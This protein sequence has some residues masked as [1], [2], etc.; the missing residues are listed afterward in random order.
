MRSVGSL[1]RYL[2]ERH[3]LATRAR[4]SEFFKHV[5]WHPDITEVELV[6]ELLAFLPDVRLLD[7]FS[8]TSLHDQAKTLEGGNNIADAL[9]SGWLTK[10]RERHPPGHEPVLDTDFNHFDQPLHPDIAAEIDSMQTRQ[11]STMTLLE[12]CRRVRENQSWGKREEAL[13]KSITPAV[14]EAAIVN[15][16]GDN[17]KLILLQ[18]MDF[19][20]NRDTYEIH[21]GSAIPSFL[22]ACRSVVAREPKAPIAKV[23][24]R[25]FRSAG[26]EGEL[27]PTA[28]ALSA[29]KQDDSSADLA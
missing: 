7:M 1:D 14:Y 22:E 29:T 2:S 9:I 17:L 27:I 11:Q 16:T 21:F 23:I 20:K 6:N 13:M 15:E 28:V 8:V 4:V 25:V 26:M 3:E 5:W 18:S 19:F 10:F 24:C 12:V